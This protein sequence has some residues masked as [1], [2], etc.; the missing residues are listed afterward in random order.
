MG[1]KLSKKQRRYLKENFRYNS[2]TFLAK[3]LGVSEK[4]IRLALNQL[5]LKRT[6]AEVKALQIDDNKQGGKKDKIN[7]R[8]KSFSRK[9]LFTSSL[10]IIGMLA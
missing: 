4:F 7:V 1:I 5:N 3:Q 2:D 6:K 10:I 8:R 9:F